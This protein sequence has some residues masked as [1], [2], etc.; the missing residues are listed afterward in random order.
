MS[1][2]LPYPRI[3]LEHIAVGFFTVAFSLR[4]VVLSKAEQTKRGKNLSKIE[5]FGLTVSTSPLEASIS[6]LR[7]SDSLQHATKFS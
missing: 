2:E 7:A 6:L 5:H 3:N 4:P 1:Q